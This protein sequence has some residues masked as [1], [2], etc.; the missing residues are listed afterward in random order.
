M[1]FCWD[2]LREI[3]SLLFSQ[4]KCLLQ[5]LWCWIKVE[6]ASD[7]LPLLL[8]WVLTQDDRMNPCTHTHSHSHTLTHTLYAAIS[9]WD[10]FNSTTK[11]VSSLNQWKFNKIIRY[12]YVVYLLCI[13]S[14]TYPFFFF[15]IK[16]IRYFSEAVTYLHPEKKLPRE[17]RCCIKINSTLP[18]HFNLLNFTPSNKGVDIY[19]MPSCQSSWN[20]CWFPANGQYPTKDSSYM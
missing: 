1:L 7:F 13:E 10:N 16:T 3:H 18:K 19:Q 15:L 17:L 8:S 6:G 5:R 2:I 14:I 20:I 4:T 12:T 11:H 9:N